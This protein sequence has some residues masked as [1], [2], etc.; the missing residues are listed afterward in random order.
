MKK[1]FLRNRCFAFAILIYVAFQLASCTSSRGVI[2]F[3][4]LKYPASMSA[5]LYDND[6][7][8]VMKGKEL[9]TVD[10]FKIKQTYWSIFYGLIPL[11]KKDMICNSLNSIVEKNRG[12]GIINL[13][14]TIRQGVVNKIYSFFLYLPS[15]VPVLPGATDITISGEV[16][17][18]KKSENSNYQIDRMDYYTPKNKIIQK[19][20]ELLEYANKN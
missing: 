12:D 14:V 5:F 13:T 6:K 3:G 2:T 4:E 15:Y 7:N 20:D 17:R 9:E 18:L 16:V 11:T 8:I 19:I 1:T 10:T